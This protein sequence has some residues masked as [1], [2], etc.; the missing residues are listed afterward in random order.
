MHNPA[1]STRHAWQRWLPLWYGVFYVMLAFATILSLGE[2]PSSFM[3]LLALLGLSVLLGIWYVVCMTPRSQYLRSHPLLSMGYLAI[4]WVLWF[5][6]TLFYSPYLFLLFG[7]YPQIFFFRA[8]P[9]KIIDTLILTGLV[10]WQQAMLLGGINEN[11]LITLV[12]A[13]CGIITTL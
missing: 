6:L 3:S 2:A 12:A 7:L 9:W 8:M 13:I 5:G 10:L 11:L 4:G 1:H